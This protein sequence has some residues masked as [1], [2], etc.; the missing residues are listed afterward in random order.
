MLDYTAFAQLLLDY[1]LDVQKGEHLLIRAATT[2]EPLLNALYTL[3]LKRHVHTWMKIHLPNQDQL[4]FQHAEEP[5]LNHIHPTEAHLI[6]QSDKVLYILSDTHILPYP[7][8]E[9]RRQFLLNR[10]NIQ[11][12]YRKRRW[13]LTL[14]PTEAQAKAA[15]MTAHSF[16]SYCRAALFLDH[17]NP[18]DAW[19]AL[20][21]R[22]ARRIQLFHG[23]KEIRILGS[24]TDIR[25]SIEG[26]T[27]IN[28]DGKQNMPSGEIYT[29]PIDESVEGVFTADAPIIT[30]EGEIQGVRLRFHQGVVV[31]ASA[32]K[33]DQA[34]QHILNTDEGSR[35]LGE[36][37]IGC[38]RGMNRFI[39]EILYDE[40]VA[41]TIHLA[42]GNSYSAAGGTNSSMIHYDFIKTMYQDGEILL[43]GVPVYQ[44]GYFITENQL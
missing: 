3:S 41:G 10:R 1:C 14:F 5:L 34:L 30:R 31:E 32:K 33:G 6:E 35:R 19:R 17:E 23:G 29:S 8:A 4:F 37:G 9:K 28:S 27:F 21:Q 7:A 36:F 20:R 43:D 11:E 15:G 2:T 16:A 26:R 40:K 44:N 18:A 22:Q 42:L 39:K 25:F 24:G 12:L 13:T 38:N